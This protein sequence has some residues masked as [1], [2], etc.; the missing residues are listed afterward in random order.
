MPSARDGTREMSTEGE[1]NKGVAGGG[2]EHESEVGG[3]EHNGNFHQ[4]LP[5]EQQ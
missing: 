3:G 5:V 2:S 4:G 1:H